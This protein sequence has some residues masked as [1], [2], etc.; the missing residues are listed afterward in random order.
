MKTLEKSGRQAS[1]SAVGWLL[2]PRK[3]GH[4]CLLHEPEKG[5]FERQMFVQKKGRGVEGE[6]E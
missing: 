1:G 2:R 5:V 4:F 3:H 6:I